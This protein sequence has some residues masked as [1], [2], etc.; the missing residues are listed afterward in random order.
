MLVAVLLLF[1]LQGVRVGPRPVAGGCG[2]LGP[3]A[4]HFADGISVFG[5]LIWPSNT[6]PRIIE[7]ELEDNGTVID[8]T[9]SQPGNQFQFNRVQITNPSPDCSFKTYHIV[10]Q[11]DEG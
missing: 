10:I 2:V 11:G 3:A 1:A 8:S 4:D 5:K 9:T 7:V 6:R